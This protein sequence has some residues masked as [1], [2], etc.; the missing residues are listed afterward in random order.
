[1]SQFFGVARHEYSMSIRRPGFWIAYTL[2]CLFYVVSSIT[3]TLSGSED[4]L[5]PDQIWPEAGHVVFM[6]NIFLPLLAGILAADRMQ[7]DV[8]MGVRELQRSTPLTIPM[9][10]LAKYLG[11]LL[12]VLVPMFL[13]VGVIGL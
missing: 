3:P 9:Y 2:L 10:V 8:R 1:M 7:R 11:V 4:I 6:Y 5:R 13:L 12:S